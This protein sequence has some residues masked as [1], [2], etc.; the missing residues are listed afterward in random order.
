MQY[1]KLAWKGLA[2]FVLLY[3]AMLGTGILLVKRL[4]WLFLRVAD[5]FPLLRN[6][7]FRL[8][9]PAFILLIASPAL[10][11]GTNMLLDLRVWRKSLSARRTLVTGEIIVSSLGELRTERFRA[12][13]LLSVLR[14]AQVAAA[15]DAGQMLTEIASLVEKEWLLSRRALKLEVIGKSQNG[16][17]KRC[18]PAVTWYVKQTRGFARKLGWKHETVDGL[19]RIVQQLRAG[20]ATL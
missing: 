6:W 12:R 1:I 5:R 20:E 17:G 14:D 3:A 7:A 16:D 19:Y 11:A 4:S 2:L 13:Y 15:E 18:S 10:I 8:A 9:G